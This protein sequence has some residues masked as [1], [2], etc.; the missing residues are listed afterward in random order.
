MIKRTFL[1]LTLIA[2]CTTAAV[3]LNFYF[4]TIISG[5]PVYPTQ[6]PAKSKVLLIPLDSRPPCIQYVEQLA[7]LAQIQLILPPNELLDNYNQPA[8][9]RALREWLSGAISQ[10]DAAII[11]TDML[12][13]G[14]LLASRNS[15]GTSQDI[16]ETLSLLQRIHQENPQVKL[17]GFSIIPRLLLSD[18]LTNGT[19]QKL[20]AKYSILKDQVSLF[21]NP[22]DIE[23]L[24]E[25]EKKIPAR[26][27]ENYLTLY[28]Q[29]TQVNLQLL[30]LAEQNIF[31]GLVLGQD[32]GVPFGLPNMEK[33]RLGYYV[34]Q[35]PSLADKVIITRGTDEVAL[36]LL[37][38]FA[39][40]MNHYRPRI[41][42]MYSEP[43]VPEM[44]MP[45]MPHTIRRTVQE[46]IALVN[47]VEAA[48]EKDADFILYVH[49][50]SRKTTAGALTAAAQ[51]IAKLITQGY[52]LAVVDLAENYYASETLLPYLI[53]ANA[54]LTKL[55]AYAGWNT[56]SNSIGTAV[57]QSSLFVGALARADEAN[58]LNLYVTQLT[59][60][61]ERFV[62]DWY[63][64]KDVQF[65]VN[66]NLRELQADPYKLGKYHAQTSKLIDRL[67]KDR[68]KHF[69]RHNMA[70]RPLVFDSPAGKR[71]YRLTELHIQAQLPWDRTF[72]I[73]LAPELS[74]VQVISKE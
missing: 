11:S 20:A 39:N 7:A 26:I 24:S 29:N 34:D 73:K 42:V 38:R 62:D 22:L 8:Q 46:K 19:Y 41:Y 10:A 45:Y 23:M 37:G 33:R 59:F 27:L 12:I 15:R 65:V 68:A 31:E 67:L 9:Q 49:A 16:T 70:Y 14:G 57:T 48:S 30:E 6:L 44:V 1:Y 52:K 72:E 51:N 58:W 36:T 60:L 5:Y 63:Y 2:V 74:I 32:D 66:T 21:E 13:H 61:S 53:T 64:Q 25:L 47:G 55:A 28:R 40:A 3:G 18:S 69:F 54:D 43:A 4:G 50:G 56:T 35:R 17:Y 71:D